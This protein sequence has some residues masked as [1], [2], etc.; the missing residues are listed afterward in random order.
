MLDVTIARFPYAL[1][2]KFMSIVAI[3]NPVSGA[4]A[5]T[6]VAARRIALVRSEAERRGL[7]AA[8]HVTERAGHARDLAA[9]SAAAGARLVIVWGG[10]GTI[11]EAGTGLLGSDTALGLVP[12]GSGNGLA[13]A[14]LVP[15][16]PRAALAVALDGGTRTI[17]AGMMAGRAF[18]NIAGI[19]FDACVAKHFNLRA[20]GSR[21]AW[22]YLAL[23]VREGCRYGATDYRLQ[24]DGAP[25]PVRALLIAFANGREYGM[26]ARIA[27]A[28][29]LDDGLLDV[30]VVEE[31]S[32]LA[33]FWHA[34][35]LVTGTAHLAPG[36]FS[37]RVTS[38]SVEADGPM[39][40]HVDGEPG[41]AEGRVEVKILPGVLKVRTAIIAGGS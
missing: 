22:P 19:G 18:F 27:A 26:G 34:R 7:Q 1:A 35:H 17:D 40:F 10:D 9:A 2:S 30:T 31:R 13:G 28:A 4:G 33:R 12:A 38:A 32:V 20:A 15:R 16:D 37:T 24:L 36:V 14:L 23:G 8:I 3:I 5:D 41:V 39:E 6:T 29:E 11:N 21:G 25:R